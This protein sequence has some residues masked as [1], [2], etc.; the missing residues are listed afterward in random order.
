[1]SHCSSDGRRCTPAC[2]V[3]KVDIL[4]LRSLLLSDFGLLICSSREYLGDLEALYPRASKTSRQA[5]L[6]SHRLS[7]HVHRESEAPS[8]VSSDL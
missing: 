8:D 5:R 6:V 7:S 3:S 2:T 1:M 4:G